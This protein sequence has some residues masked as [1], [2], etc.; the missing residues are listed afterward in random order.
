MQVV[1]NK[2]IMHNF[3]SYAYSE[4]EFNKSGFIAV[5]GFNRNNEDNASSNGTGKCFGKDTEVLM[6]DGSVKLVQDIVV[7]DVVMGWDS[8]P[9]V[10]LETHTGMGDMYEVSSARGQYKYT[11]NDRHLLC[12]DKTIESGAARSPQ[13]LEI[14]VSDFLTSGFHIKRNYCQYIMPV[15]RTLFNKDDLRIDPYFLGVW[16]GDGTKDKPAIT[17]MDDEIVEYVTNYFSTFSDHHINVYTKFRG[18][19]GYSKAKTYVLSANK[20]KKPY[21]NDLVNL[22]KSYNLFGNKHIPKEYLNTDYDTRLKLLAGLLDTDGY[23]EKER[24]SFEFTQ[25]CG[26]L[27][28]DFVHL[29]RGL[30]F[31]V[32]VKKKV[33]Y[34]KTYMRFTIFG[35]LS[36]IPTRVKHKTCDSNYIPHKQVFSFHPKISYIGKGTYYGFQISGDGKFLLSNGLV[37][38]NSSVFNSI[39]WCLTGSTPTGV[40]DVHNRYVKEDE[41]WVYLSF[42]VDG[43]EY[44]IKRF[45][46]PAGMEF[47][48][49]GREIENKG[50][51]DAENILSQYLPNITEKL[52]SSVIILGQGLPNKLTNHTPSGRKEILE[53]LSNSDFMIEDIK[54]RLSKRLTTLNDKKRELEDNILQ[55]STTIENN[56]RLITDYQYELNHLSPCDILESDLASDKKQYSEL[57][58]RVFDSY[59][60]ELKKLYN[61]KAKI[62]NEPNITDLSSIDVKLAEMRT[63][64]K[65]KID[66]YK[67][68]SS[69]TDVCPTCGQK[70]IGVHKPDTSSLVNEINQLKDAGVQLKNQRDK[71]E[72]DNNAIIAECNKKYQED[73]A[74]IQTSI[75]KLE[76]LQQKVQREKQLVESQ[77]K[78]LLENIS[79]IQVEIDSYNN[80]RNTYLSGIEKATKENDKY[81]TELDT[82]KSELTTISQRIDIQNKMNTLTKRDFRGVLL[83]NCISYL[84]SKMKEFSLEVFNT[85]KLSMELSGNNVSIKLD[86]KEYESLSGGE[87]TKVDIII[88][89]S[90]RDMLCK[91][92]NFS[93]NILVIDEVTDFLDE[94]SANNVYNL[95]MSKLNDVSSVYIISHRK[96]FTIPTDGVMIIE[97][98][99][100]KI[101][102]IIQ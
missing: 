11:C 58:A 69:V 34:G 61:E 94:Q 76:Q 90:I 99:T 44:T 12:L 19:C 71:I 56:K 49:D 92:A 16:L 50:I 74:S 35:D 87:K 30:G 46:K 27:S 29:A 70:L 60:E 39:I 102:R 9:R 26:R 78:N 97:K 20:G 42:T 52:L 8:T 54:D 67:E 10:V 6:Y 53:Q 82:L 59:D 47:T 75:E 43:K 2:L 98:D 23:Y 4:Y 83:S 36:K 18:S 7:G 37:V 88:Q 93:S 68:L 38:H 64:L 14:S 89:L 45:Y 21:T 48:V 55:L 5:K 28:D 85:D 77:M 80:K 100:D 15:T 95:F 51:R 32:S 57:S 96:D 40:K 65:G 24:H 81:S 66:K 31:K 1:F 73:V 86:G 33:V 41:T 79:K 25:K 91:Y 17:T 101:S 84:N 3:L 72:Q 13:K 22:L 63:T 62:K